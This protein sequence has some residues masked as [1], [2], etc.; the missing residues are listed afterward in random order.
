EATNS[1]QNRILRHYNPMTGRWLSKDPIAGRGGVNLYVI[2]DNR[3]ALFFDPLGL[4]VGDWWD[5]RSWFHH[6]PSPNPPEPPTPSDFQDEIEAQIAGI[7]ASKRDTIKVCK[8]VGDVATSA[9]ELTP[10]NTLSEV[11]LGETLGGEKVGVGS[12]LFSVGT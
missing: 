12:R 10:Q 8:T 5:P 3:P 2:V 1:D 11:F 4:A 7:Y 9:L 6:T